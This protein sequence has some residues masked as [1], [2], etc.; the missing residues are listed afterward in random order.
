MGYC[1]SEDTGRTQ[2]FVQ[3]IVRQKSEAARSRLNERL[4]LENLEDEDNLK[5]W[6]FL[7]NGEP[8]SVVLHLDTL[9]VACN[10]DLVE[11][12]SD[13]CHC[14][15]TIEFKV[16]DRCG[17]ITTTAGSKPKDGLVYT[18]TIEGNIVPEA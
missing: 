5:I 1:R 17:Q 11:S 2:P 10:G 9:E 18:L 16:G 12:T 15:S 14:G 4:G 8:T 7:L 3:V 6:T 13:F